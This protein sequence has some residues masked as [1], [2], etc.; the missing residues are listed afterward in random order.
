VSVR[1]SATPP[2]THQMKTQISWTWSTLLRRVSASSYLIPR[3]WVQDDGSLDLLYSV[4]EIDPSPT[5]GRLPLFS[6]SLSAECERRGRS[7]HEST[8]S[9][10]K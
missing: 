10:N 6:N 5:T 7:V 3:H 9:C 8:L 2:G 4:G 1:G